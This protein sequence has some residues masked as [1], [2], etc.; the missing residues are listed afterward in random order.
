[1]ILLQVTSII[2]CSESTT[3]DWIQAIGA[4]VAIIG[5][6]YGFY[7]FYKDSKEKQSQID[8]LTV[9][10]TES[11]EQTIHLASQ[12]DQMIEGNKLQTEY[13]SLFQ[14]SVS[15]SEQSIQL[16]E[17]QKKLDEKRNKLAIRPFFT[18]GEV[19]ITQYFVSLPVTNYG[20]TTTLIGYEKLENNSMESDINKDLNK[21]IPKNKSILLNLSPSPPEKIKDEC[22]INLKIIYEDSQGNKYYQIIEGK[23]YGPF[24]IQKQ[25]EI[26]S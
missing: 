16:T 12:V 8:T 1:M 2:P 14:K 25:V 23:Y 5:V 7:Q 18:L 4:I 10:A 17:E 6:F 3:T 19:N 11:K 26:L 15:F 21:G 20:E 22:S 13:I 9:L 24:N